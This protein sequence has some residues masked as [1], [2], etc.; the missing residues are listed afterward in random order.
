MLALVWFVLKMTMYNLL[1]YNIRLFWLLFATPL[2]AVG[3][4]VSGVEG[5]MLKKAK[6]KWWTVL[7]YNLIQYVALFLFVLFYLCIGSYSGF[8]GQMQNMI[9]MY[10][11]TI[12]LGTY[13]TRRFHNRLYGS[14]ISSFAFQAVMITSAAIIS[15][16]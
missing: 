3:Y 5:D 10:M 12:P 8:I 11:V 7:L 15:M 2:M 9:I 13:V 6:A 14:L 4:Y 16:F 1:P